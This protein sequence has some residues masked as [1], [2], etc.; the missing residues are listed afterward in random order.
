M[1]RAIDTYN[2]S[3]LKVVSL[4]RK[5][6]E[7][8]KCFKFDTKKALKWLKTMALYNYELYEEILPDQ[9]WLEPTTKN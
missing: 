6:E 4:E 7:L 8:F 3:R 5:R 2:A 9:L 1:W